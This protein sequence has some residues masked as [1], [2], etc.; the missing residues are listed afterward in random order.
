MDMNLSKHQELVK[1]RGAWLQSVGSR[2]VGRDLATVYSKSVRF[3]LDTEPIGQTMAVF[4]KKVNAS[5]NTGWEYVIPWG[6][7]ALS[8]SILWWGGNKGKRKTMHCLSSFPIRKIG[9]GN[10]V[11]E[12]RKDTRLCVPSVPEP[13]P[14]AVGSPVPGLWWEGGWGEST[15]GWKHPAA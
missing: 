1:D 6:T 11:Q 13:A 14:P 12:R 3:A 15:P 8:R 4:L 7:Q 9:I 5:M 10:R 2:R